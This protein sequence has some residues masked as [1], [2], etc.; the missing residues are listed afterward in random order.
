MNQHFPYK[1][2][3]MKIKKYT[4]A[5]THTVS[6]LS[7]RV[8]N[9]TSGR[10]SEQTASGSFDLE[11]EIFLNKCVRYSQTPPPTHIYTQQ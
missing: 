3:V 10:L 11:A 9:R 1:E 4:H 8:K 7:R 5:H 2:N 6:F